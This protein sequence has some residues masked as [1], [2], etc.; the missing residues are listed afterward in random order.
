MLEWP[1]W[2]RQLG[3]MAWPLA[4]CAVAA[5][6][7]CM[8][9]TVFAVQSALRGEKTYASLSANLARGKTLPKPVRDEMM[10]V[11]LDEM[12]G[13][14]LRGLR[15]LRVVGSVS[16]MFGLLGTILGIISAFRAVALQPGPVSPG[17]IAAGL[18]EAMLTTAL[19]LFIALPA[20]LAAHLFAHLSERQL[21][22][23]RL[24]LNRM[25]LSLEMEKNGGGAAQ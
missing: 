13:P 9:R 7:L 17:L 18:W 2:T 1:E 5:L 21:E 8:E 4:A 16:P 10:S 14:Y 12:R 20:L 22:N 11:M 3:P 15:G 6:A 24:R 23:F 19:G 25:S